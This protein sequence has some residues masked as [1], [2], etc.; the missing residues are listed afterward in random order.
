MVIFPQVC[1]GLHFMQPGV[2]LVG[3]NWQKAGLFG[4]KYMQRRVF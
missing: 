1:A 2:C 3:T 4:K